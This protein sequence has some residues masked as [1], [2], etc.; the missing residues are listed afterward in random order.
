MKPAVLCRSTAPIDLA[1]LRFETRSCASCRATPCSTNVPRQV[2]NAVL[3]ARRPD[4]GERAAAPGWSDAVARCSALRV[5]P[6]TGAAVEGHWPATA[7]CRA[8]S[9]TPPATAGTSSATGPASSATGARSRS[10]R[11]SLATATAASCSSR[12]RADAV[13]P[14]RRRAGGAALVRARVPV[15]RGDALPRRADHARAEPRATGDAVVRDMFYDG[16]PQPE[17]GAIVCRVAPSFL[18]FGNFE[19]LAAHGEHDLL[20]QLADFLIADALPR[21]RRAVARTSTRAAS[22]RSAGARRA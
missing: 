17:P 5:R 16:N 4:A 8:C 3:L 15:Q 1:D 14:P 6:A 19:I 10:A 18:R 7:C 2:R 9:P 20:K 22:T 12:A 13:L 11:S 21:A